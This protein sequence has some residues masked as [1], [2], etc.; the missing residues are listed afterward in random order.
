MRQSFLIGMLRELFA[1]DDPSFLESMSEKLVW[2]DLPA[3]QTLF[4][5]CDTSRDIYVV[6]SGRLRAIVTAD[7]GMT[8][9]N[10]DIGYGGI[11]GELAFLTAEPRDMTVRALRDSTLIKMSS[12]Q[13]EQALSESPKI[14]ISVMR[15]MATR[16]RHA[17]YA[18]PL[19]VPPYNI[20]IVPIT[21]NVDAATFAECARTARAALGDHVSV[22]TAGD[23]AGS[24]QIR[25]TDGEAPRQ[26]YFFLVADA[27]MSDWSRFCIDT[28][29][30]IILL[31]DASESADLAPIEREWLAHHV[32]PFADHSLVLL[33]EGTTKTPNGTAAWLEGRALKRHIHLRRGNEGDMRRFTRLIAGRAVALVLAGGGARGYAHA[34][35]LQ[36]L[37]DAG[38]EIDM[39]GGTSIGAVIGGLYAMGLQGQAL[40]DAMHEAF[41][42]HGSVVGDYSP[43][44]LVSL[45][46]GERA[47]ARTENGI[48]DFAG[49]MINV[50]DCWINYFCITAD[51]TAASQLVIT[52]GSLSEAMLAS[53]AIPG[54]L[55]PV[56]RD[57]HLM[58]DG[59]TINNFPVDVMAGYNPGKI[60]AVDLLSDTVRG[61]PF[62]RVP[63]P[64]K[65]ALRAFVRRLGIKRPRLMPGIVEIMLRTS[66]LNATAR[67]RKARE[68]TDLLIQPILPG[69]RLLDWKKFDATIAGGHEAAQAAIAKLSSQSLNEFKGYATPEN[70]P[71]HERV[72]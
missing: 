28:A 58:V 47:R 12:T 63:T 57:Q 31:G 49:S 44:P 38:I 25:P 41:V 17:E 72:S 46:R 64:G 51:F 50:E 59:G 10:K 3:G 18:R 2:L 14:A 16:L 9:T 34:G 70:M 43:F 68:F 24:A 13:F 33:H 15:G 23:P 11:I 39:I 54:V 52:R 26:S 67:Q 8:K 5:Q 48:R 66:F 1:I 36:A 21:Q 35:V 27:Q 71:T 4:S 62:K 42:R 55:P 61:V 19:P 30:E 69:V 29:D 45:A 56:V 6:V 32:E 22:L 7:D 60:I 65:L 53:Y 20:C 40:Q 37:A